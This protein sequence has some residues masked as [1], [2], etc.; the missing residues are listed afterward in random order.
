MSATLLN[1]AY[2][3]S[4]S[5]GCWQVL[6]GAAVVQRWR[7]D[8]NEPPQVISDASV[9]SDAHKLKPSVGTWQ[10][11]DGAAVEAGEQA[12][13]RSQ[14]AGRLTL[15]NLLEQIAPAR[16]ESLR[17][18]DLTGMALKDLADVLVK[19]E[20]SLSALQSLRLDQNELTEVRLLTLLTW[21]LVMKLDCTEYCR[22]CAKFWLCWQFC[23]KL[24]MYIS[25]A[26][27]QMYKSST[28]V[29]MIAMLMALCKLSVLT[30]KSGNT[31]SL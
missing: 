18:L 2:V 23:R 25:L 13:S 11:L 20:H 8:S 10:V 12:S 7:Q 28:V 29:G 26:G 21:Y 14:Y 4:N 15:D 31:Q 30:T 24:A 1:D 17:E 27:A 6:D 9:R 22:V 19:E 3:R 16:L 5:N